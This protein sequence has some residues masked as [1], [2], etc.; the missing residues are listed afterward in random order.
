MTEPADTENISSQKFSIISWKNY[1]FEFLML[2]LAVTLGFFVENQREDYNDRQQEKE[3]VQSIV[4]DIES[5]LQEAELRLV[6]WRAKSQALD[7]LLKELASPAVL[8]NSNRAYRLW[9]QNLSYRSFVRHDGTIAQLKN[10]GGLRLLKNQRVSQSIMKYD[11]LVQRIYSHQ[12]LLDAAASDQ[13][14]YFKAFDHI[15]FANAK[16][17]SI[18]IPLPESSRKVLNEGYA[19]G[20]IW[21]YAMS[22]LISRTE[23]VAQQGKETL[24]VVRD[25]YGIK[26]TTP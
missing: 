20:K 1:F 22:V 18:P 25:E 10:N 24:Q 4:A 15:A 21:S 5:D 3:Y 7:S 23:A 9:S 19:R 14:L 2:F 13:D 6:E 11:Q 26:E 16:D 17:P 8:T 12:N